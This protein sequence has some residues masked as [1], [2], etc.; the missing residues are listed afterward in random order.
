MRRTPLAASAAL[1]A[2]LLLGA[3]FDSRARAQSTGPDAAAA[4]DAGITVEWEVKNRFRLFRRE[5]DF[6]R[7]VIANR[8]GNQLAAEHLLERDTGGRGWAQNQVEHLC[9]NAAGLLLDTCDRDGERENYLAP[10]TH[11]VVAR[12]TGAVPP[13]ATCNWSFDDGTIPPKQANAPCSQPVA[14]APRL[15]QA[16]HRRRRHHAAGQQRRGRL[17]RDRGPR[18][19]DR[20]NGRLGRRRR[21]QSRPAHRAG[22]RGLLLPALSRRGAGRI[23]PAEPARL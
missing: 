23:F 19:P 2:I 1:L 18:S 10:K 17:R 8:A 16:D 21:R 7:H 14:A 20:G 11:L 13:G 15:R 3:G 5:A 4:T 22:R 12:L 6:Q 9:V